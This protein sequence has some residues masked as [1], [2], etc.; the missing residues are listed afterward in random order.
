MNQELRAKTQENHEAMIKQ[1]KRDENKLLDL[2]GNDRGQR[3]CHRKVPIGSTM[4]TDSHRRGRGHM[5]T[6]NRMKH[7]VKF[8]NT[9]KNVTA[10]K[11]KDF[12]MYMIVC[13]K[14]EEVKFLDLKDKE[15]IL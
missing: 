1:K 3:G 13:S 12:C 15:I 7:L 2:E 14:G 6:L 5:E 9:R 11:E 10:I 4:R 8:S